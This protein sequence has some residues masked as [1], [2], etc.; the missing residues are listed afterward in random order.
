MLIRLH[1]ILAILVMVFIAGHIGVH[2]TSLWGPHAHLEAQAALHWIYRSPAVEPFLVAGLAA[3]ALVGG[4]LAWRRLKDP[5]K[6]FW[7][8]AQIVSGFYLFFFIFAHTSAALITRH[9]VGLETNFYWA[10]G[11]AM[12]H[13]WAYGFRPYYFLAILAL[14]THGA[15]ALVF[16]ARRQ[17]L[18]LGPIPA[19]IVGIGMVTGGA[20]VAALS[21]FLYDI[22]LPETYRSYFE[23][24]ST[25]LFG[26]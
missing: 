20:I 25:A 14:F 15:A 24:F 12:I 1:R 18:S 13:P 22:E 5:S 2:L 11:P 4:R 26:P 7:H 21:G 23:G 16:Y 8:W 6:G 10:S 19:G 3:Q 17:T 9:I